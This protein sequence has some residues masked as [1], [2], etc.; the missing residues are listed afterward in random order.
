MV[1]KVASEG[2]RSVHIRTRD[3][4]KGG[5]EQEARHSRGLGRARGGVGVGFDRETCGL[6]G[7]LV[8]E[9]E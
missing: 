7:V 6:C 5:D 9:N 3:H 2:R 4:G 1:R 8:S